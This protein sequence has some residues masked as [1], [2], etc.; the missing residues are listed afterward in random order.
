MFYDLLRFIVFT[1][2]IWEAFVD[3]FLLELVHQWITRAQAPHGTD[4]VFEHGARCRLVL[5]I[6]STITAEP[7]KFDRVGCQEVASILGS[8]FEG[9]LEFG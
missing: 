4:T 1:F 9:T 6:T 5:C 3:V 7:S 2:L 8:S